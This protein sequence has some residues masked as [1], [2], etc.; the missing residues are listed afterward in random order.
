[1]RVKASLGRAGNPRGARS[2][3]CCRMDRAHGHWFPAD[4]CSRGRVWMHRRWPAW[5]HRGGRCPRCPPPTRARRS[6]KTTLPVN[7]TLTELRF[8]SQKCFLLVEVGSSAVAALMCLRDKLVCMSST[9]VQEVWFGYC[10][11]DCPLSVC[12]ALACSAAWLRG[13]Q[14]R[15]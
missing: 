13:G 14:P 2:S 6:A 7:T 3:G 8:V 4:K 12:K 11:G 15:A 10:D 5:R 9:S 1:V